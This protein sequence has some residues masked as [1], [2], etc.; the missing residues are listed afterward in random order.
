VACVMRY[1]LQTNT[2]RLLPMVRDQVLKGDTESN[3][4]CARRSKYT[5]DRAAEEF[6]SY[7]ILCYDL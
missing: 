6:G 4:I 3:P 5:Y 1:S 2:D 7:V